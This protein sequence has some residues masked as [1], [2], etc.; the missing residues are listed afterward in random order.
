MQDQL[1]FLEHQDNLEMLELLD[2]QVVLVLKDSKDHVVK[3]V[4]MVNLVLMGMTDP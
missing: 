3:L 4:P 1:D 2:N